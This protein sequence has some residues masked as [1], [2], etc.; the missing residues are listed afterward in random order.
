[1]QLF[2]AL[3]P[4]S[5]SNT[6]AGILKLITIIVTLRTSEADKTNK[7]H[8]SFKLQRINYHQSSGWQVTY[9][10]TIREFLSPK[11]PRHTLL[12]MIHP[13]DDHVLINLAETNDGL[14]ASPTA[15]Y[16]V[17]FQLTSPRVTS[18]RIPPTT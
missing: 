10:R 6:C 11:A 2:K 7:I 12:G 1:M 4:T 18:D 14:L 3:L 8:Y 17:P 5:I 13:H 16:P 9:C 15:T